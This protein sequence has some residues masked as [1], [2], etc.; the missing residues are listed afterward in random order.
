M[1]EAETSDERYAALQAQLK[2]EKEKAKGNLQ[3][4]M[5]AMKESKEH[6]KARNALEEEL[7]QLRQASPQNSGASEVE[8]AVEGAKAAPEPERD[9]LFEDIYTNQS[10]EFFIR[11]C[12]NTVNHGVFGVTK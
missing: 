1:A 7:Q 4:F 2:A 5:A 10:K 9:L 11:A 8:A 6:Q 3:K 12:D